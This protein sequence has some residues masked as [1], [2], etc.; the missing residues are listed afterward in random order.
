MTVEEIE[1]MM[2]GI[3]KTCN[4][5]FNLDDEL[6]KGLRLG[7]FPKD[8]D[9]AVIVIQKKKAKYVPKAK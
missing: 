2:D 4:S 7:Q 8:K 6:I 9:T 3:K 1:Y 5:R